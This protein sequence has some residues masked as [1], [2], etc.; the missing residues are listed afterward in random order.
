[1]SIA[2]LYFLWY[3]TSE[4]KERKD[5]KLQ[6]EDKLKPTKIRKEGVKIPMGY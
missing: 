3:N 1:L 2:K 5:G 6:W 4:E